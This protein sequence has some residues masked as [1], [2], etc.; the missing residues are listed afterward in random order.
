MQAATQ[1]FAKWTAHFDGEKEANSSLVLDEIK[2]SMSHTM[3][4]K[5]TSM[6]PLGRNFEAG[7]GIEDDPDLPTHVDVGSAF[8]DPV[9]SSSLHGFL[10]DV[11]EHSVETK[12]ATR[13]IYIFDLGCGSSRMA[14][15]I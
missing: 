11:F 1:D 10:D 15:T 7:L 4:R 14:F 6:V 8:N 3:F 13:R 9:L 12:K 2:E 5:T